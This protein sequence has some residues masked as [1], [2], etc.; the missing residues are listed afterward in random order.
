MHQECCFCLIVL[1]SGF[2]FLYLA[3]SFCCV[4]LNFIFLVFS[5]CLFT[6]LCFDLG[7]F[8]R[9][10]RD[11]RATP[12][13][14]DVTLCLL[15]LCMPW[16]SC[17]TLNWRDVLA[18]YSSIPQLICFRLLVC[19]LF[20]VCSAWQ[21]GCPFGW[22]WQTGCMWVPCTIMLDCLPCCWRD[23][24]VIISVDTCNL[25]GWLD[26]W[27]TDWLILLLTSWLVD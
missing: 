21:V 26:E 8:V 17:S 16:Q 12:W 22:L 13:G 27:L 20:S 3:C 18:S 7:C 5:C 19:D 10:T 23:L 14:R 6:L 11:T 4:L 15:P 1:F 9:P 2:Y 24:F 25:V